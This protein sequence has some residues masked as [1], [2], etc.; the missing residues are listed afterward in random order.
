VVSRCTS[1]L[2]EVGSKAIKLYKALSRVGE[3]AARINNVL[4]PDLAVLVATC[5]IKLSGLNQRPQG[6][7]A[8]LLHGTNCS[9]L[10][11]AALVLEHQLG[12][13]Q[14]NGQITM[15]LVRLYLILGCASRARELWDPLDIKRAT[16]DSLAPIFC[17]RISAVAPTLV[18]PPK[19]TEKALMNGVQSHYSTSLKLRMPRKFIDALETESYSSVLTIPKYTN[20]L[21]KSGT[22]VMGQLEEAHAARL[23][24]TK[25]Y[26]V[27]DDRILGWCA[28][29]PIEHREG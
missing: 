21:R 1:C 11:Q 13:T 29:A 7:Q 18:L 15:F 14:K 5:C 3:S 17:D 27:L 4:L 23:L 28:H 8:L 6:T 25:A 16:I 9:R 10:L 19:H 26:D 12:K 20:E 24:A 22:L 2:K